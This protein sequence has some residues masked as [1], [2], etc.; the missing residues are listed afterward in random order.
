ML[1]DGFRFQMISMISWWFAFCTKKLWQRSQALFDPIF[2]KWAIP[3]CLWKGE[4]RCSC[5]FFQHIGEPCCLKWDV[6]F[7]FMNSHESTG[8][9]VITTISRCLLMSA[10]FGNKKLQE[11]FVVSTCSR[12]FGGPECWPKGSTREISMMRNARNHPTS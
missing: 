6:L 11:M 7:G 3:G 4:L 2:L 5:I 10:G 9:R 8:F 12:C 1:V